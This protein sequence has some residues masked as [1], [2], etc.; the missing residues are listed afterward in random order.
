MRS[1]LAT[2]AQLVCKITV[3]TERTIDFMGEE[4]RVY[5][6]PSLIRDI[7][8]TCRELIMEHADPGEDSVGTVVSVRHNAPTLLGMEVTITATVIEV[9]RARVVFDITATDP[10]E[11]IC[12]GRHERFV[13]DVGKTRQRLVAKAQRAAQAG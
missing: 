8:H 13:V 5:A 12:S 1:S 11:E 4:C 9:D 2:G 3:D 6:T 7:E 10:L